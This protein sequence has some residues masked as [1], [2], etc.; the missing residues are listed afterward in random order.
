[1]TAGAHRPKW[2]AALDP[3]LLLNNKGA[4]IFHEEHDLRRVI[5]VGEL[6]WIEILTVPREL[7]LRFYKARRGGAFCDSAADRDDAL[8]FSRDP[9]LF[10]L[11]DADAVA[12]GYA[13]VIRDYPGS[14]AM[15]SMEC[16]KMLVVLA[17][18][19]MPRQNLQV[20]RYMESARMLAPNRMNMV[21]VMNGTPVSLVR[22]CASR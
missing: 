12:R 14:N 6:A 8:M 17:Q 20:P 15:W 22:R 11:I 1:L 13:G 21:D 19:L 10:N 4:T 3:A 16:S 2:C 7:L 18:I 9:G 5:Q